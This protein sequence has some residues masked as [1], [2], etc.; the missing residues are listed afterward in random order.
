MDTPAWNVLAPVLGTCFSTSEMRDGN[1]TLVDECALAS[2][3]CCYNFTENPLSEVT[4]FNVPRRQSV[5]FV[6]EQLHSPQP[7]IS[8]TM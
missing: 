1:Q 3:T 7:D 4:N 5:P 6:L 2:G 8:C